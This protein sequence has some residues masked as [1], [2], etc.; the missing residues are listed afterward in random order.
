MTTLSAE[1]QKQLEDFVNPNRVVMPDIDYEDVP[2]CKSEVL[3]YLKD[4]YLDSNEPQK[5]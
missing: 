5:N 3:S 2:S 4:K 1:K